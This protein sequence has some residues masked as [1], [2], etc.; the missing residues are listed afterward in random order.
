[1][2][3]PFAHSR[4]FS[5]FIG[6]NYNARAECLDDGQRFGSRAVRRNKFSAK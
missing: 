4:V 1:M 2:Q 5:D 6:E 3:N